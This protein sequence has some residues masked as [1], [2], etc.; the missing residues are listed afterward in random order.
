LQIS[1]EWRTTMFS[2]S[3]QVFP[4][5]EFIKKRSVLTKWSLFSCVS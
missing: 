1:S 4:C 5:H 3:D 2:S